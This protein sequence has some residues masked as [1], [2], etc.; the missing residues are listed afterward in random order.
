MGDNVITELQLK[1]KASP[2]ST[3]INANTYT[4]TIG[5]LS[6][7]PMSL[8][9]R[10]IRNSFPV[11]TSSQSDDS[12]NEYLDN[13]IELRGYLSKWTNYIYGWQPRYIVLKNGTLSY[14]KSESESDLG[15]RGAISLSK[16]TIKVSTVDLLS[17]SNTRT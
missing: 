6:S 12:E 13:S 2:Y 9:V 14:Y 17:N 1:L 11:D 16:A 8:D 4:S 5:T 7:N 10:T 3:N 15:C